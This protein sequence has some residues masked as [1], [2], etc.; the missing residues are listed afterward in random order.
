MKVVILAGGLGTRLS[1]ETTVRPKPMVEIGS[2]PIIWHIMKL[3]DF[4]GFRDFLICAGYKQNIIKDYFA[5]Y[6]LNHG[7]IEVS[8][9]SQTV[10]IIKPS[11]EEWNVRVV[12]TGLNTMTGGRIKRIESYIDSDDDFMFTYGDGLANLNIRELLEFHRKHSPILTLTAVQPPGRFGSVLID[13]QKR[14]TKFTEKPLGDGQWI[15]AGYYVS[16]KKIFDFLSS[17]NDILESGPLEKISETGRMRAFLHSGFWKPMDT[18]TDKRKLED[19]W[20]SNNAPWK[21]WED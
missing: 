5:K 8:T 1:E 15:N 3:Y 12:D 6:A 2:E 20:S 4:F 17:D 11:K 7:D 9:N 18:L 14:V 19:M 16:S 10:K 13:E 21:I